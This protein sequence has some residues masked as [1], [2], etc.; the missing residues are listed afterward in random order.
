MRKHSERKRSV[1]ERSVRKRSTRK[2]AVTK[3]SVRN[4]LKVH[5]IIASNFSFL[6]LILLHP[7]VVDPLYC[8]L[9]E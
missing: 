1:M 6:V 9:I 7:D 5:V 8:K 3:V 4:I 2:R